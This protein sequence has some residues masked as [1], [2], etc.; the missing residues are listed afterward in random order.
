V[1]PALCRATAINYFIGDSWFNR[2][3]RFW[4]ANPPAEVA[5]LASRQMPG[6][7]H[8]H[9]SDTTLSV[10]SEAGQLLKEDIHKEELSPSDDES[11]MRAT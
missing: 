7:T 10:R 11:G 3:L 6:G 8:F 5:E 1:Y 2:A 4:C 9:L